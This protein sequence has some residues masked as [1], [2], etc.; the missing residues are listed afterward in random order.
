MHFH[1]HSLKLCRNLCKKALLMAES[2]F[3]FSDAVGASSIH[4]RR[5]ISPREKVWSCQFQGNLLAKDRSQTKKLSNLI[6]HCVPNISGYRTAETDLQDK[7]CTFQ[8]G[9]ANH[10][11]R[12]ALT[13]KAEC[14]FRPMAQQPL[15]GEGLLIT[16]AS[17]SHSDTQHSS[18]QV[19][20]PT[21]KPPP[22]NTQHSQETHI[23]VFSGIRNRN[24]SKWA[25]ADPR[26]RP[27]GHRDRQNVNFNLLTTPFSGLTGPHVC[28]YGYLMSTKWTLADR[29]HEG[30]RQLMATYC[31]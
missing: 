24:P 20:S 13:S 31:S 26:L 15:V 25:A 29:L 4:L 11:A 2:S 10:I 8:Y 3:Q 6:C 9:A 28:Q 7:K 14:V 19:I 21:K 12:K 17:R 5:K 18:G 1:H 22:D 30:L 23:Q 27:R 16:D